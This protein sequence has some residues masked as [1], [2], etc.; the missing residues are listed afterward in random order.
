M[1]AQN[2]GLVYW[3][4]SKYAKDHPNPFLILFLHLL[5]SW[6]Q[7]EVVLL[8]ESLFVFL[9]IFLTFTLGQE[10]QHYIYHVSYTTSGGDLDHIAAA[11]VHY[12]CSFYQYVN[13]I[14]TNTH[15]YNHIAKTI[16][17][18]L[19]HAIKQQMIRWLND[20]FLCK[21]KLL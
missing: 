3:I 14:S 20:L 15:K 7:S 17:V 5:S 10:S 1:Y 11:K 4:L 8:T 2:I 21:Q 12:E 6:T 13:F 16:V 19:N 9:I 18:T